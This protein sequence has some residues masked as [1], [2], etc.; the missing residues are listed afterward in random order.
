MSKHFFAAD[1][2][3]SS[4]IVRRTILIYTF[5]SCALYLLVNALI[6]TSAETTFVLFYAAIGMFVVW[7]VLCVVFWVKWELTRGTKVGM[8]QDVDSLEHNQAFDM[9]AL[10]DMYR[11]PLEV[12]NPSPPP[13]KNRRHMERADSNNVFRGQTMGEIDSNGKFNMSELAPSENDEN[14]DSGKKTLGRLSGNLPA[15][16]EV[17]DTVNSG[18]NIP[19]HSSSLADSVHADLDNR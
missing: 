2:R 16:R 6:Y 3:Q 11:H 19:D 13:R 7:F 1:Q 17:R 4:H 5:S 12:N 15:I 8:K 9:R 18:I 10:A 14:E